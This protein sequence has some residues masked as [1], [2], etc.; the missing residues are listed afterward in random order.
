MLVILAHP[1]GWTWSVANYFEEMIKRGGLH[2]SL[3]EQIDHSIISIDVRDDFSELCERAQEL[4]KRIIAEGAYAIIEL[5]LGLLQLQCQYYLA[6]SYKDNIWVTGDGKVIWFGDNIVMHDLWRFG[7][8]YAPH[9]GFDK[10]SLSSWEAYLQLGLASGGYNTNNFTNQE[11]R[12]RY[13]NII[14]I[15]ELA[16]KLGIRV[17]NYLLS[18]DSKKIAEFKA[19]CSQCF[20][21]KSW[22]YNDNFKEAV[23]DEAWLWVQGE[24]TGYVRV[25]VVGKRFFAVAL[26]DCQVDGGFV[27]RVQGKV[28]RI[29]AKLRWDIAELIIGVSGDDWVVYRV[30]PTLVPKSFAGYD[31]LIVAALVEYH[32]SLALKSSSNW[33]NVADISPYISQGNRPLVQVAK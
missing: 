30:L 32:A 10:Y 13:G 3:T 24:S 23:V 21:W 1:W 12:Y 5:P 17:P 25:G 22:L 20:A 11:D 29:L 16:V 18:C 8:L 7:D 9:F 33:G 2:S 31:A 28:A 26:G 6:D 15:W 27:G 4:A 19:C 14:Q